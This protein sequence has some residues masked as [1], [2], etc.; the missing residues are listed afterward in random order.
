MDS[1]RGHDDAIS[2]VSM[3]R[4]REARHLHRD[5]RS[6]RQNLDRRWGRGA[7]DPGVETGSQC[8]AAQ[9]HEHRGFPQA[10]RADERP[11]TRGQPIESVESASIEAIAPGDPPHPGMGIEQRRL[12]W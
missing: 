7:G 1:R 2:R 8:K 10:D 6:D 3:A 11:L 5:F 9:S 4:V 12:H